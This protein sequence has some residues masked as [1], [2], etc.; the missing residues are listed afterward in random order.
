MEKFYA[1]L[2]NL[3]RIKDPSP[4]PLPQWGEGVR[5]IISGEIGKM[6]ACGVC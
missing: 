4:Y 2:L 1:C 6:D 5:I 3:E